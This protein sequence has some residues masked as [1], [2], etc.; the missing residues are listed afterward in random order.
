MCVVSV[1]SRGKA[2]VNAHLL[3]NQLYGLE[4]DVESVCCECRFTWQGAGECTP[5]DKS[6]VWTGERCRE[7]ECVCCECRFTWQ[8]AGECTPADKSLLLQCSA[9]VQLDHNTP[10]LLSVLS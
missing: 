5:A 10:A 4:R 6:V 1:G 9:S 3:I 7:R 2:P 8:G